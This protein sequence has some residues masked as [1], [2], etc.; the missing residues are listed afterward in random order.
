MM[1]MDTWVSQFPD[2]K[3]TDDTETLVYWP[4]NN[5]TWLLAQEHFERKCH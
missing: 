4:L 3:D 2:D 1:Q 5:L